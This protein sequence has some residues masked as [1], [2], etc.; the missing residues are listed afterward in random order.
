MAT[1][2]QLGA[3]ALRKIGLTP[4]AVADQTSAGTVVPVATIAARTLRLLGVNQVA[5]AD[6]PANSGTVSVAT[7]ATRALRRLAVV[8]AEETPVATD[9]T[10]GEEKV[11]AVHEALVA[12][13][14]VSWASSAIPTWVAE[15]Y[16]VMASA[17][18]APNFGIGVEAGTLEGARDGILLIMLSGASG[19]ALAEAEVN[20]AHQTLNAMGYVSWA[21]DAVPQAASTH[22]AVMAANRIGAAYGRPMDGVAY[23]E[24]IAMIRRIT[25]S[26]PVGQAMAEEKIRAVHADLAARGL[27][28]WTLAAIPDYAEE[29]VVMMAAELLAPECGQPALSGAFM[30][31]EKMI[32]RFIATPTAGGSVLIGA[33]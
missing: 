25:V 19:Q 9:Q 2:A 21:V 23:G 8:A 13:N 15:H 3:R 1:V 17:L 7:I 20:A 12:R 22:Y 29:P 28:R 26:G 32:R 18:L 4:V 5:E 16:T 10:L 11:T 33:F 27:T 6:A 31:G 30:A 14:L 24:A